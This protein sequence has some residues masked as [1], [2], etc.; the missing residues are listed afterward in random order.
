MGGTLRLSVCPSGLRIGM[1]KVFGIRFFGLFQRDFFVPWHDL[2]VVRTE[3][4]FGRT[5][6]LEFGKP[7]LGSLSLSADVADRLAQAAG[8][9]W[10]EASPPPAPDRTR[11]AGE[12][13][14]QWLFSTAF[15]ALF[16]TFAPRLADPGTHLPLTA[17][18]LFPA[19]AIGLLTLIRYFQRSRR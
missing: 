17:T 11:I 9:N 5:A 8:R 14:R 4:F 13:F 12:M 16:F 3:R 15:A 19:V 7:A 18:V 1:I 2:S 6:R 10:P